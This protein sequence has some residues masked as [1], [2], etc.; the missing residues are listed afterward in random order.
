M[1]ERPR[2]TFLE[3]YEEVAARVKQLSAAKD[4]LQE[5]RLDRRFYKGSLDMPFLSLPSSA[6]QTP[7][8]PLKV[9]VKVINE[10]GQAIKG[11]RVTLLPTRGNT[12]VAAGL[13]PA[14]GVFQTKSSLKAGDYRLRVERAGYVKVEDQVDLIEG[15]QKGKASFTVRLRKRR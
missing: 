11:A 6:E 5:P 7:S 14:G 12:P 4:R 8:A 2:A 13:S 10:N 1:R 15:G 3:T 9:A